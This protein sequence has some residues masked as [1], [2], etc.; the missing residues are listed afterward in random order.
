MSTQPATTY[1]GDAH[2]IARIAVERGITA[3]DVRSQVENYRNGIDTGGT[4][5]AWKKIGIT[6]HYQ[7]EV[8]ARWIAYHA[9]ADLG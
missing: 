3:E 1:H 6:N 5:R 2:Q 8:V 4:L 7:A 9:E